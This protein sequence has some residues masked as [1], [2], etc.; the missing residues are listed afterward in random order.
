LHLRGKQIVAAHRILI[1]LSLGVALAPL[2]AS[3]ADLPT[4]KAPPA[5]FV[6]P[7][8][9]G[10]FY[11]GSFV[12]G[13]ASV[14]ETNRFISQSGT[15]F[16]LTTGAL[17]GYNIESNKIVYG[18]EGDLQSNYAIHKFSP[19]P[20]M[21]VGSEASNLYT[22]HGRARLGYDLGEFM[23]Y[24][25][26][27]VA[28]GRTEQYLRAPF[29]FDGDTQSQ[30]GW[31]IGAG[32]DWKVN[33]PILGQSVLRGEYLYD[34]FPTATY[35]LNGPTFRTSTSEHSIRFALIS[36]IGENWHPPAGPDTVDWSGDYVG[37]LVG[38]TWDQI[39]TKG[40]G[41]SAK[42]DASGITGGIYTGHNWVFGQT[43]LGLE[44]ATMLSSVT[45]HGPEAGIANAS[46][47]EYSQSDLRGRVG[48]AFGRFLPF[49][50]AG[51]AYSPSQQINTANHNNVGDVSPFSWTVG[52]G[53]DYMLTERLVARAEYLYSDSFDNETTHLEADTCCSQ[54]R[55]SDIVRFGLAYYFH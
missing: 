26:G 48:Y 40:F 31:T 6:P 43:V 37:A 22:L 16:G 7:A 54:R 44:G 18:L 39:T 8:D 38:G 45:G 17:V 4:R 36:R 50:A 27:G 9:W 55:S 30:V 53:I 46:Y 1:L 34:S 52:A 42:L 33:L 49:F 20:G 10:G 13:N 29:E 41:T 5:V 14:F 23:P 19:Q 47:N 2:S 11:A 15:A 21:V 3:A 24:I 32:L 25:A 51:A 12:G 35:N 28:Y